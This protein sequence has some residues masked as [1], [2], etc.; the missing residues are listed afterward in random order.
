MS[1]GASAAPQ[2]VQVVTG[3]LGYTGRYI[4]RALLARGVR[5]RTL[6]G[7]PDRPDPFQGRVEILPFR[8]DDPQ[9]LAASLA[10]VT[11]LY[12]TYW[13]RFEYGEVTFERAVRNSRLLFEAARAAGVRRVVHISITNPDEASSLPYFRGKAQVERALRESGLSFAILRPTVMFGREDILINNIAFLLRR[14][15]VF[16]VPGGGSYRLQPVYVGDVADLA[17]RLGEAGEDVVVD[18]V[19]PE[20]YTFRDLV[21]TIGQ[22][23]GRR[24]VLVSLPPGL[25]MALIRLVGLAVR[26]VLL[27]RE[28][29][30]GLMD[31]RLLSREPP[32]C[33]TRLSAWL[34]ENAAVL[35]VRYASELARHYC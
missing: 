25:A 14:F 31:E 18:A 24:L 11:T 33:P 21:R 34:R 7:H 27:T 30:Q 2:G 29:L 17:V 4:A 15:P 23:L 6:T 19:G 12:N 35:G 16:A 28:E 26:D 22:A 13:V 32:T 8:F 20:V 1:P 5:V 9:A 3:A 10:G